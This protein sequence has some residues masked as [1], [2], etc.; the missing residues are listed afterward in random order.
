[1]GYMCL[2]Q[3]WFSQGICLGVG[4][5]ALLLK[6][7]IFAHWVV[8]ASSSNYSLCKWG[9]ISG[10]YFY[11]STKLFWRRKWQPTPIFLPGEFHGQRKLT[12]YSPWGCKESDTTEWLT[13][14]ILFWLLCCCCSVAQ[15]C[16]TCCNPMYCSTPGLPV[17]HQLPEP[18][19][20]HVHWVSDA[21]QPS[22]PLSTPSP[23]APIFLSIRV[24]SNELA[25]R[26]R[27]PKDWSFSIRPSNEYSG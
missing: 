8:L 27:W 12:G 24:F 14:T 10:L 26:I 11:A 13:H 23:P 9:F 25:L 15:S 19:Q 17:L 6:R 1:M 16:L 21:I 4:F 5:P 3:F 18:A 22:H 2:F 20:I 7:L